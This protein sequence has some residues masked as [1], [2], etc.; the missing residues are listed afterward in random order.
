[1][2]N[3]TSCCAKKQTFT[4]PAAETETSAVLQDSGLA[5]SSRAQSKSGDQ[6]SVTLHTRYT[7]TDV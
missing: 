5:V 3:E 6:G 2:T 1:V 4:K 7:E